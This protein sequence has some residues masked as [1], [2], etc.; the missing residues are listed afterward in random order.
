MATTEKVEKK[1][2]KAEEEVVVT[3][4]GRRE[5]I[6]LGTPRMKLSI[7]KPMQEYFKR[8]DEVPRWINDEPGRLEAAE[9]EDTYRFVLKREFPASFQVGSGQDI[10]QRDGIDSRISRVVGARD[11][12]QP[13]VA[14]LMAK[15]REHYEA[16]QRE[17]TRLIDEK[18]EAMRQGIDS[19]GRP[20][21][22]EGRYIPTTGIKITH[23]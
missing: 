23:S 12:G 3:E 21:D 16:D 11:S 10:T 1:D 4:T 13:I 6:P 18:E 9:H 7:S 17:K 22:K 14:Y 20:G 15:P 8:R 19:Y 2:A 5:R